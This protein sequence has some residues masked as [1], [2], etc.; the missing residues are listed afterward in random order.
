[1]FRGCRMLDH[2]HPSTPR[3]RAPC[4]RSLPRP[5]QLLTGRT[6]LR[7]TD[8][9]SWGA[10]ES[11]T[12]ST[13]SGCYSSRSWIPLLSGILKAELSSSKV[14]L[15][16]SRLQSWIPEDGNS[17]QR[18]DA[19]I[20]T[21]VIVPPARVLKISASKS[22]SIEY[23]YRTG[24]NPNA[25]GQ[26]ARTHSLR[27]P[28]LRSIDKHNGN[29]FICNPGV[30]SPAVRDAV[31][32]HFLPTPAGPVISFSELPKSSAGALGGLTSAF[33]FRASAMSLITQP[34]LTHGNYGECAGRTATCV[35][36]SED[37][38]GYFLSRKESDW[39]P[40]NYQVAPQ[41]SSWMLP[42]LSLSGH[43]K[44]WRRSESSKN[45]LSYTM[46]TLSGCYSSARP[47][48][49]PSGL[50]GRVTHSALW[51]VL[52]SGTQKAGKRTCKSKPA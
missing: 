43:M 21:R 46:S 45:D 40:K 19:E 9:F 49:P 7:V 6:G 35:M 37:F 50:A 34:K 25:R 16:R 33:N 15:F 13:L 52:S 12:S 11:I 2:E 24:R 5:S 41:L 51:F 32:R 29:G 4:E 31:K 44:S 48:S 23:Q 18:K 26:A 30:G 28:W 20:E 36:I 3:S 47:A 1:M 17:N 27:F 42:V 38:F 8:M 14:P 10:K 39:R 22:S